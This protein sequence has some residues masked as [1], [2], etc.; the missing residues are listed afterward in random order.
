LHWQA[1]REASDTGKPPAR[2]KTLPFVAAQAIDW[3]Q[4][5]VTDFEAVWDV[6]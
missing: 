3:E 4:I 6:E 1:A 5:V 2:G